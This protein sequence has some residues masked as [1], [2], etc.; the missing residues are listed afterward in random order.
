MSSRARAPLALEWLLA[1]RYLR[2]RTDNR[3]VSFIA[4]VGMLGIALGVAVLVVVLSV[5]NG[6]EAELKDRILGMTAHATLSSLEGPLND[7][8]ALAASAKRHPGVLAAAPYVE[9]QAML[10]AGEKVS[11][12]L[13]RGI[14]PAAEAGINS[15]R[16]AFRSGSLSALR[17]GAYAILLGQGLA[18]TLGVKPG[19]RVVLVAPQGIATPAGLV[20]RMRRLTVAGVFSSGLYEYDHH[21]ALMELHD[22]ARIYRL[23]AGVTGLRLRLADPYEAQQIV[24]EVAVEAGGGFYINDWTRSHANFFRSIAL[25]KTIMFVI[26]LLVLGV[27]AFNIVSTLVML[28]REKRSDIA[29]LRTLGLAPASL[30]RTFVAQG[31]VIGAAGTLLGLALG[32]LIARN[33]ASFVRGLEHLLGTTLIDARVYYIDELP[34]LVERADLLRVGSVAFVL[35]ALSTLYPAWRAARTVPAEALRHD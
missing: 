13:V 28:V 21:V 11:G 12:T 35:C 25:T 5:M 24:R 34:A 29:I 30:L 31:T 18:E 14:D 6:F 22:A 2:A 10:V 33:L 1:T 26:L 4:S 3:F 27:A 15:T 19:D 32:A 8:P 17:E 20:P 16:V 7:W 23:G 9:D